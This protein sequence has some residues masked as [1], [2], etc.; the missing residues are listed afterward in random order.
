MAEPGL[1]CVFLRAI[2]DHSSRDASDKVEGPLRL[3]EESIDRMISAAVEYSSKSAS[4]TEY[5]R[6]Q[7]ALDV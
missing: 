2:S 3:E 4:R 7:A 5:T 1:S 6:L